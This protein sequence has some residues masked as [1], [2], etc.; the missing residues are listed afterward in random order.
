MKISKIYEKLVISFEEKSDENTCKMI[1]KLRIHGDNLYK[2]VIK[3]KIFL[4]FRT[5]DTVNQI[6]WSDHYS[7]KL[8]F[9]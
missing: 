6:I 3:Q 2:N 5:L 4:N 7:V 1:Q 8:V 9:G